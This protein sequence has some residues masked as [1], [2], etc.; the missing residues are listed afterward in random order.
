M[1]RTLLHSGDRTLAQPLPASEN[2]HH[3]TRLSPPS[4]VLPEGHL[5]SSNLVSLSPSLL[6]SRISHLEHA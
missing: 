2:L 4:F 5:L 6:V 1:Q 3:A